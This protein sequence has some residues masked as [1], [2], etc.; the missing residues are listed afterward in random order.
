MEEGEHRTRRLWEVQHWKRPESK[1][2]R[3]EEKKKGE[4]GMKNGSGVEMWDKRQSE[5]ETDGGMRREAAR[6]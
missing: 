5:K 6:S 3:E 1:T 2:R 4:S